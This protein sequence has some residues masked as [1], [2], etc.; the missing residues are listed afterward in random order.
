[1]FSV[2]K[3]LKPKRRFKRYI[4]VCRSGFSD[5]QNILFTLDENVI[6]QRSKHKDPSTESNLPRFGLPTDSPHQ[7]RW[8]EEAVPHLHIEENKS[9]A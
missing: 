1:M 2:Y 8:K 4:K 3:R 6:H 5:V 9:K 7:H